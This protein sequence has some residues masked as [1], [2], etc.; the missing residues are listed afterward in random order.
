MSGFLSLHVRVCVRVCSSALLFSL[1]MTV[2][3][4]RVTGLNNTMAD[5]F[6]QNGRGVAVGGAIKPY[7][8]CVVALFFCL[9]FF[10]NKYFNGLVYFQTI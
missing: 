4:R 6:D 7:K 3:P 9:F 5:A 10:I 8:L 2:C 1:R